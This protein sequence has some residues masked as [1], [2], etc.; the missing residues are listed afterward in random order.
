[1]CRAPGNTRSPGHRVRTRPLL[2]TTRAA[3]CPTTRSTSWTSG[4]ANAAWVVAWGGASA[5]LSPLAQN[6]SAG[7]RAPG[8]STGHRSS[9]LRR[10]AF[11]VG[12]EQHADLVRFGRNRRSGTT[13]MHVPPLPQLT[14]LQRALGLSQNGNFQWGGARDP[15]LTSDARKR[16]ATKVVDSQ[17]AAETGWHQYTHSPRV[18]SRATARSCTRSR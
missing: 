12:S 18:W 4:G 6:G 1:M 17:S 16:L 14:T 8:L 10:R 3:R 5:L 9:R 15:S 7:Q 11:S 13:I 2:A